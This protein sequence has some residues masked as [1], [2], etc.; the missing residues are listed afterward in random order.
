MWIYLFKNT[1]GMVSKK[2][3]FG[4]TGTAQAKSTHKIMME[5]RD[6]NSREKG[7]LWCYGLVK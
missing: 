1:I 6:K 4:I 7:K 2:A 5:L 3:C